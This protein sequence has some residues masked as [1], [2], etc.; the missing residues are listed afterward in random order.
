MVLNRAGRVFIRAPHRRARARRR[1]PCL[2]DAASG[3]DAGEDTWPA[4]LR[5]LHE[6]TSIRSVERL[7]EI[8]DWLTYDI[9][10]EI[11]GQAWN[12]KYRGQT[13]KWYALR[14][15]GPDGEID[16][17]TPA[18]GTSQNSSNGAGSRW[19]TC[20]AW[21]CRSSARSMSGS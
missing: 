4:A 20:P 6:E 11:V 2:A 5:E 12:G 21:W 1:D 9:P 3:V 16:I 15:T 8:A 13:Q 7:G 18:A 14:F 17:A 19:P 10:R